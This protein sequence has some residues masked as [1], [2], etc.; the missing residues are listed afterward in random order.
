MLER[1]PL[2]DAC[3][4]TALVS[5]LLLLP[6]GGMAESVLGSKAATARL[7]FAVVVPPVFRVLEVTSV[8]GGHRYRVWTNMH[9]AFLN[10]HQYT[11][12]RVG[13]SVLLIPSTAERLTVVHGL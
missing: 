1:V 2:N 9:S 13:E 11:F 12:N 8:P 5:L 4:R 10:G 3:V 7:G 6:V